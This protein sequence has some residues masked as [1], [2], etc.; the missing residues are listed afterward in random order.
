MSTSPHTLY[1]LLP[2]IHRLR[3]AENSDELQS[4]LSVFEEQIAVLQENIDQLYDDQFIETC[5]EWAVPYIGDLIGYKPLHNLQGSQANLRL[6]QRAEVANTIAYRRRKGTALV[7]E[8]L[9][10]D[11][12]GWP[13]RAVEFF[14]TLATTQYMNHVRIGNHY[15]T[16]TRD[17]AKLQTV[18]TAFN[19]NAH[20]ADVRHIDTDKGRHNIRNIGIFLW[21]LQSYSLT[22]S[23]LV[24]LEPGHYY[25]SPL[26]HDIP[27]FNKP[28]VEPDI[29]HIAE[30]LNVPQPINRQVMHADIG[31]FYGEG[32]SVLIYDNFDSTTDQFSAVSIADIAICCLADADGN[33]IN[34]PEGTTIA[35]DP[36]SG[37]LSLGPDRI[38]D[39]PTLWADIH[40]GFSANIAGGEY[41]R[42]AEFETELTTVESIDNSQ[43]IQSGLTAVA[44]NGVVEISDSGRYSETP[45]ISVSDNARIELRAA[46]EHR[47]LLELSDELLI[48]GGEN[49]SVTLDGLLIAGGRIRVPASAEG[50]E[51]LRLRHCTLVPGLNLD[52]DGQPTSAGS[53]SIVIES[54][55]VKLILD[56]CIVG[57]VRAD[58]GAEV[59][60]RN[61]IIDATDASLVAYSAQDDESP[62]APLHIINSTVIG[63]LHTRIMR[64]AS[65]CIFDASLSAA[66]SWPSPLQAQRKQ[67]GCVRFCYVPLSARLPRRYRCQPEFAINQTIQR[68][69]ADTGA[70]LSSARKAQLSTNLSRKIRPVYTSDLYDTPAYAQLALACAKEIR[71]G[72][73]DESEM[74]VFHD[75]FQPQR[76]T[77]VVLRMKE[78]LRF[79]LEAGVFYET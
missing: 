47:P 61:S 8:Q 42:A 68:E 32:R 13:A 78:Y 1:D 39:A 77:N 72:A 60:V 22:K 71:E 30:P 50:L 18:N 12:T 54:S 76:H 34:D 27:L 59:V 43:T 29:T 25:L 35:I 64:L 56:R 40:T 75:L 6:S 2:T 20:A 45:S 52:V 21:R 70:A 65:N 55:N 5:A 26:Q 49:S 79:G 7:L 19:R 48:S 33:W 9:A 28:E 63:K 16:D 11:V 58:E 62:G 37:R 17:W 53:S 57:G 31:S 38:A 66:D 15:A 44:G 14:Q 24:E 41:E 23:P 4:F 36:E 10:R 69:E 67:E 74:G 46:N 73:D 3:D 51:V